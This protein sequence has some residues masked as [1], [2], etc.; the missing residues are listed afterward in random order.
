[1]MYQTA[2]VD[3]DLY[4]Q[5]HKHRILW[6]TISHKH[7]VAALQMSAYITMTEPLSKTCTEGER[8]TLWNSHCCYQGLDC[9]GQGLDCQGQNQVQGQSAKSSRPRT[10]KSSIQKKIQKY[11][12][13]ERLESVLT[14]RTNWLSR[15]RPRPR[16]WLPRPKPEYVSSRILEAKDFSRTHPWKQHM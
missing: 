9:W 13:N 4:E 5:Y 12:K 15:P 16:T 11:K 6:N 8:T 14:S 10:K 3:K 7:T 2:G 1:M